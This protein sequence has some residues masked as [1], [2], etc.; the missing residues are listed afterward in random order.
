MRTVQ[1]LIPAVLSFALAACLAS[2]S[3]DDGGLESQ[4]APLA[5]ETK[6]TRTYYTLRPDL[7]RCM[8]PICGGYFVSEVNRARTRCADGSQA[9]ECYVA[10][11]T[12][13]EGIELTEGALVHGSLVERS[14]PGIQGL[15][16]VLEADFVASAV[17]ESAC[18]GQ[19][20]LAY[21]TGIRCITTPCESLG[22]VALNVRGTTSKP[23][24]A[25]SAATADDDAL[26]EQ[27][28]YDELG[29]TADAGTGA[30][31]VGTLRTRFDWRRRTWVKTLHVS[32]VYRVEEPAGEE[33]TGPI[34]DCAA[35]PDG[36]NYV[37]GGCVDGSWTCGRLVC[38]GSG[39]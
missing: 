3:P 18:A 11:L 2:E 1:S 21:D 34:I 28:F 33:C 12:A 8:S 25:F 39:L 36:C 37:G 23:D 9:P 22:V 10:E 32:N 27:A 24:V 30:L 7:R 26:L 31:A 16:G 35:P 19:H 14:Y 13:P 4:T 38:D 29:T 5:G 17:L 6:P 20:V 15:W